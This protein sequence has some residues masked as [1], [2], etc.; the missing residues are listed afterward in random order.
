MVKHHISAIS[1]LLH[2]LNNFLVALILLWKFLI[3]SVFLL[4]GLAASP[5][6]AQRANQIIFISHSRD[7]DEQWNIFRNGIVAGM[8][9]LNIQIELRNPPTGTVEDMERLI[10]TAIE[11]KPQGLILS[12]P[13][14]DLAQKWAMRAQSQNIPVILVGT[15]EMPDFKNK[16]RFPL[17]TIGAGQYQAGLLA[18]EQLRAHGK[19][20]AICIIPR[21]DV[22]T[23][24]QRCRG[25]SDA[26]GKE[27][28][29][30]SLDKIGKNVEAFITDY[31][32]KNPSIQ[33]IILTHSLHHRKIQEALTAIE[34]EDIGIAIFGLTRSAAYSIRIKK[35]LLFAIDTQ[36]F[37]QGY[38]ATIIFNNYYQ[39]GMVWAGRHIETGPSILTADNI[40]NLVNFAGSIR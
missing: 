23:Y 24:L 38:M 33:S 8:N 12:V 2:P 25:V 16:G 27:L 18:G 11:A 1:L 31:V 9:R 35:Q 19:T 37:L 34:R 3:I 14:H 32:A 6:F 26:I 20:N 39:Y 17:I 28:P 29:V 7:Y 10:E 30:F 36:P 13:R 5:S 4:N 15:H 22:E 40:R 21:D